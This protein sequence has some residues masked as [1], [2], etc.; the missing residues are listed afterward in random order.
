MRVSEIMTEKVITVKNDTPLMKVAELLF[1]RALTGVPVIDHARR[2]IGIITEY[3]LLSREEH[4][5]IPSYVKLLSE[6]KIVGHKGAVHGELEMVYQVR[7]RDLMTTPVVTVTPYTE[8]S[9]AARIF[10]E[11]RIN[12]LPVVDTRR[13][14]VG[15]IS[16]ADIVK[17][18]KKITK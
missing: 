2:V 15:I 6:F 10:S 18:F 5:H 7:A 9:E 3:D 14:L 16:R 12:P 17:L 11:Q 1:D 8:V 4:I 13:H